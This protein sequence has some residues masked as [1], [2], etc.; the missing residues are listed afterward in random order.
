MDYQ[1]VVENIRKHLEEYLVS[2]KLKS[3]V[4]GLS[5]GI[6]SALCTVLA[7]PV[8]KKLNIALIGRSISIETNKQEEKERGK[9][10]GKEFC[11]DFKEIDLTNLYFE[12]KNNLEE[13]IKTQETEREQK[14]RLGN[15]KVRLRMVYLYNL[16]QKYKGMVL[17]TDNYTELLLGFWTLHGDV[18]DYG[19]IQSLWKTEAYA[20]SKYLVEN[21]LT[22]I[23]QKQSLQLSIDATPTDGLGITNS[24]LE[25][26]EASNYS[27]VD[28]ILKSYLKD[29]SNS[30][31]PVVKRYL[32][33]EYKRNNPL[34]LT[35]K[36]IINGK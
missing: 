10:T 17:S 8:C 19:M 16:A 1:K 33:S 5:G 22:T 6:D 28:N 27:E 25:Q 26:I 4:I 32:S 2:N 7:A 31:H 34:N 12:T 29:K 20:M 9:L 24:D 30:E 13:E 14:I 21:E 11:T 15:I 18:G 23:E 36:Q 35:R 3:L